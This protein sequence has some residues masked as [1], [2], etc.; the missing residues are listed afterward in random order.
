MRIHTKGHRG[1]APWNLQR[2]RS[3]EPIAAGDRTRI[4]GVYIPLDW[5]TRAAP[6]DCADWCRRSRAG[7]TR[8]GG[9]DYCDPSRGGPGARRGV[10]R[11]LPFARLRPITHRKL[12]TDPQHFFLRS[13]ENRDPVS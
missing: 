13:G 4:A 1:P 9:E 7:L 12:Y 8:V 10:F 3:H 6:P 11:N 2:T 5:T